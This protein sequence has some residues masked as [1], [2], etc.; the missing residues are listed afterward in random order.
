[1]LKI[2]LQNKVSILLGLCLVFLFAMI[3][4]F[5]HELFYDPFLG[6]FEGDFHNQPLPLYNSIQLFLSLGFRYGMN[7]IISLVLM[8]VVFKQT[9]MIRFVSLLYLLFF[10]LLVI[11]FFGI[12]YFCGASNNLI[13]FYIRRFLIQPIFVLLFIPAFFYQKFSK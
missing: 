12:I 9:E 5:E 6:Y 8:Y 4:A 7:M 13:L 2:I 1:M 10:V 3:R 11:C